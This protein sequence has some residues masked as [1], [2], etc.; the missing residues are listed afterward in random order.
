M[1]IQFLYPVS[2]PLLYGILV[3]KEAIEGA[4]VL[5]TDLALLG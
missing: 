4:A 3:P 2:D 1:H 5:D